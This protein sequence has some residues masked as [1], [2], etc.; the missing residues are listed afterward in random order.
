MLDRQAPGTALAMGRPRCTI[1]QGREEVATTEGVE[2]APLL[3]ASNRSAA[4]VCFGGLRQDGYSDWIRNTEE[5]VSMSRTKIRRACQVWH[6]LVRGR[7]ILSTGHREFSAPVQH[8][9]RTLTTGTRIVLISDLV[10]R[11]K[12]V[13]AF[14]TLEPRGTSP[15]I[16][17]SLLA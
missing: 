15:R 12:V 5:D 6:W 16:V 3:F 14:I 2:H 1:E 11:N 13:I 4:R 17:E 10:N 9:N 7:Q 8:Q